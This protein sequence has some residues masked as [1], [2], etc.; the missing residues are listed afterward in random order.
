VVECGADVGVLTHRDL[1]LQVLGNLGTN[2]ARNTPSGRITFTARLVGRMRVVVSVSDTGTGIPH[3][4]QEHVFRR[5]YRTDSD[6]AGSGL[7]LA[8]ASQAMH[9][10]GGRLELDSAPGEG[11]TLTMSLPG[12]RLIL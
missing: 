1:F 7:G 3:E 6:A 2:A 9:A 4:H 5:F 12:A 10:L 11:T 8:I